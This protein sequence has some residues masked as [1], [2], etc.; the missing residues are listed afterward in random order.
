MDHLSPGQQQELKRA[1]EQERDTLRAR[2]ERGRGDVIEATHRGDVQDRGAEEEQRSSAARAT[3]RDEVRLERVEAA[4]LRFEQGSYGL[5][6]D[7]DE[8]IPFGRLKAEPTA[9]LTIDAQEARELDGEAGSMD[10][11]RD[12]Y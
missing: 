3:E 11:N 7:T 8:P 12:A 9:T 5:C 4:L 10:G 2:V 6:E 1:L